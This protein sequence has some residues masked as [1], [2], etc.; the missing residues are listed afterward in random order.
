VSFSRFNHRLLRREAP[1]WSVEKSEAPESIIMRC[2]CRAKHTG[3][4]FQSTGALRPD[5]VE[6]G[7]ESA[8]AHA[9][10]CVSGIPVILKGE[11]AAALVPDAGPQGDRAAAQGEDTR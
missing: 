4:A 10:P 9:P 7:G 2:G 6:G 3:T 5:R 11:Y 1:L 8:R